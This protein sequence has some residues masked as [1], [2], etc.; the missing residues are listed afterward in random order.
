MVRDQV[1]KHV[2]LMGALPLV[3][4]ALCAGSQTAAAAE[5]GQP[6]PGPNS[7]TWRLD[8]PVKSVPPTPNGRLVAPGVD[9]Y[10]PVDHPRDLVCAAEVPLEPATTRPKPAQVVIS[11]RPVPAHTE[12]DQTEATPIEP[13][14][15]KSG[16][17]KPHQTMPDR[18]KTVQLKP[19]SSRTKVGAIRHHRVKA[20]PARAPRAR[21]VMARRADP[22]AV[23][24]VHLPMVPVLPAAPL[25][26]AAPELVLSHRAPVLVADVTEQVAEDAELASARH[27]YDAPG[28]GLLTG[29][30][31][32]LAAVGG[33]LVLG[34]VFTRMAAKGR[35]RRS[36][37]GAA[38]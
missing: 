11:G 36:A 20:N 9:P 30:T 38:Q 32:G 19:E 27:S 3:G 7:V 26:A 13:A 2:I 6:G 22:V 8:L 1:K 5:I 37:P 10:C 29:S 18:A 34:L 25:V 21:S 17:T 23:P 33:L 4:Y 28:G 31:T 12:P 35:K 14:E 16:E 15:T 24:S